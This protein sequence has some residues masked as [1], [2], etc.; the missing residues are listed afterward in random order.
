MH[1]L[2]RSEGRAAHSRRVVQLRA[3][4]DAQLITY[5]AAEAIDDSGRRHYVVILNPDQTEVRLRGRDIEAFVLGASAIYEHI[6]GRS[7]PGLIAPLA[8]EP[9]HD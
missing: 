2:I 3:L 5:V 9:D 1:T 7:I 6:H 4:H 8:F